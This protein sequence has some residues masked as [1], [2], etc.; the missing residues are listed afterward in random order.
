[1]P[2][3][4]FTRLGL[5]E[6][7]IASNLAAQQAA[8]RAGDRGE[9]LHSMDYLAYAYLQLGRDAEA[10]QLVEQLKA[11]AALNLEDFKVSYAFTALPVRYVVERGAWAE[12]AAL[13]APDGAPP[14]VAAIVV[15]ARALGQAR[16]Q[17][18]TR[19]HPSPD[20]LQ[21]IEEQL[22]KSGSSY[23]ATEVRVMRG[24]VMAWQAH[25]AH[26][27]DSAVA[28]LA[29]A[30]DLE[31]SIEKLPVTPGPIVPAREQ[32]GDLLRE[33][34]NYKRA[35]REYRLSLVHSPGR[36]GALRGFE[37]ASARAR[38]QGIPSD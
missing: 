22:E 23:W 37:D 21:A 14:E 26:Q 20:K 6:D 12:A 35:A 3:H 13:G 7:S 19:N 1:M 4:I 36:R 18:S 8:G 11:M 30:A 38:P 15:W 31:D 27:E 17:N 24:E 9:E 2:S 10:A 28:L 32:L 33:Q 34:G 16:S 25:A 29:E 5:W